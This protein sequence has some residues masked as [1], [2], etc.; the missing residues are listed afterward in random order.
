MLAESARHSVGI[1]V[2]LGG[3]APQTPS[4]GLRPRTP[5]PSG[6]V[7]SPRVR[8]VPCGSG[9]CPRFRP[10]PSGPVGALWVRSSPGGPFGASLRRRLC[11]TPASCP[12]SLPCLTALR[13]TLASLQRCL[14]S[15]PAYVSF[16][17]SDASVRV[18]LLVLGSRVRVVTRCRPSATGLLLSVCL[19]RGFPMIMPLQ[20]RCGHPA[21]GG[22]GPPQGRGR[23]RLVL[24]L[25]VGRGSGCVSG[26]GRGGRGGRS[27]PRCR[28]SPRGRVP[29]RSGRRPGVSSALLPGG[30]GP[31]RRCSSSGAR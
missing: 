8:F 14:A 16:V 19:S 17:V 25:R 21:T 9:W 30:C 13:R 28:P 3:L 15:R 23:G 10:V 27:G 18:A 24:A 12:V 2:V 31:G 11:R 4:R 6:S 7:P 26:G 1:G 5:I 29:R 22:T 20:H